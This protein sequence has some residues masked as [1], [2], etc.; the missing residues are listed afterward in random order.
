MNKVKMYLLL[1]PGF[2][3]K[4]LFY[5]LQGMSQDGQKKKVKKKEDIS[6]ITIKK[7]RD[8]GEILQKK[9]KVAF[10]SCKGI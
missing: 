2:Y 9:N 1:K 3:K 5:L 6:A 8:K 7:I 4:I 10:D